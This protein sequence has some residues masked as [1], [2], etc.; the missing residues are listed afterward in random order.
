MYIQHR[1]GNKYDVLSEE[2]MSPR[3][4]TLGSKCRLSFDL[5]EHLPLLDWFAIRLHT[6]FLSKCFSRRFMQWSFYLSSQN[7][8]I[9]H[10][11]QCLHPMEKGC[12]NKI[13]ISW[14]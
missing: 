10:A 13:Q 11:K 2:R 1:G 8:N 4:V 14:F 6:I 3:D 9:M 5:D 7:V 12:V